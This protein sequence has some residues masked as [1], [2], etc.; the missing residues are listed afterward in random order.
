MTGARKLAFDYIQQFSNPNICVLDV[1]CGDAWAGSAIRYLTYS[2][3]DIKDGRDLTREGPNAELQVQY[4]YL[5]PDLILSIYGLQHLLSEEA[6]CWTLLRR[7]AKP[8]TKFVYVGRFRHLNPGREMGR[9]DPLNA[10]DWSTIRGLGLASGWKIADFRQF[11]YW[12]DGYKEHF[13]S[14]DEFPIDKMNAFACTLEP[15][16]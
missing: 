3:L 13:S 5:P 14:S 8:T 9:A 12:E 7:I 10:H 16:E 4:N 11:E 2:G 1:C 6:R 15:I